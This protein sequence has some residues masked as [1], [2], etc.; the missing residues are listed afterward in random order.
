MILGYLMFRSGYLS[1]VLG[2]LWAIGGLGFVTSNVV[3]VL[4]PASASSLLLLPTILAALLLAFG[5]SSEEST[6]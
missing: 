2:A 3:W 1:R 5:S 6:F 4:T